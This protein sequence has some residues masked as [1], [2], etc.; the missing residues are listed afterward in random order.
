MYVLSST[1]GAGGRVVAGSQGDGPEGDPVNIAIYPE[2]IFKKKYSRI[3][4]SP[5]MCYLKQTLKSMPKSFH[6]EI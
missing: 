6:S 4:L 3:T 1:G 2:L 5:L